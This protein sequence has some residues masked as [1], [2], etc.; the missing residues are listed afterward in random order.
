M[1][2]NG[3]TGDRATGDRATGDGALGGPGDPRFYGRAGPKT[4]AEIA[5]AAGATLPEGADRDRRLVGV[6]P[7][8]AATPETVSFLDNKRYA[9][10]LAE[11]RAGAV[12]LRPDLAGAVPVCA[13]PLAVETPYPAWARVCRLFHPEPEAQPGVHPSA[14]VDPEAIIDPGAEIGPLAVIGAGAT[15]G[16]G[17]VIGPQAVI[18]AGVAIGRDCRIGAHVSVSHALI[19]ERVTL[20]PGVRIG[21]AGFG[22][23]I[24]GHGF[25]PV[26]QLGRVIVEDEA[27]IGANTTIDRGSAQDTVIGRATRIDNLVQIAHNVR[28]GAQGVIVAQAGI[29]GSATLGERVVLAAQ[30]GVVGHVTVGDGAR[31]GAQAGVMNDVEPGAEVLG[32]PAQPARETFRQIATLRRLARRGKPS[33]GDG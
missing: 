25:E 8:D 31:I 10:S 26:P 23:A 7:L 4:L 6:A 16:A 20:H 14:V 18:G 29:A 33:G 5:A 3:A 12:I 2:D 13:V 24:T 22:F 9:A 19:G 1:T 17:T 27:D 28:I 32:S 15:I 21:Q 11:T 30:S